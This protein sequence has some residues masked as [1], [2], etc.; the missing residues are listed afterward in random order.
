[1]DSI[2]GDYCFLAIADGVENPL[3]LPLDDCRT[4]RGCA[5]GRAVAGAVLA[6]QGR[7]CRSL[8]LAFHRVPGRLWPVSHLKSPALGELKFINWIYSFLTGK[9]RTACRDFIVMLKS[10]SARSQTSH[11]ARPGLLHHR[12][13]WT[14][15]D[16]VDKIV[17]FIQHPGF[18]KEIYTVLEHMMEL[19]STSAPA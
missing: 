3:N 5:A 2:G 8:L 11:P 4:R 10:A 12:S 9:I 15:Q 18:N 7:R 16:D 6:R 13:A 1:M 17:K 14:M 19:C